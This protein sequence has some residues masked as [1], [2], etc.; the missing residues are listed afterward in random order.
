MRN[1]TM[2]Y[3]EQKYSMYFGTKVKKNWEL[4]LYKSENKSYKNPGTK[5]IKIREQNFQNSENKSYKH[6]KIWE[7]KSRNKK[8]K[9]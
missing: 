7:Q 6:F 4:K 3:K 9:I 5:V 2:E 8:L 1:K